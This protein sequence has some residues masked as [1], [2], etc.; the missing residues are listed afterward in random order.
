MEVTPDLS[1]CAAV[2]KGE[3]KEMLSVREEGGKLTVRINNSSLDILLNCWRKAD[4]VLNRQLQSG[5]QSPA[6]T[7]GLAIHKALEIFY[8][9]KREERTHLKNFKQRIELLQ[10]VDQEEEDHV[11]IKAARGFM[12]VAEPL[13]SLPESDKRS[14]QTGLWTLA[15]YFECYIDD[16][17]IALADESGPLVE[18]RVEFDLLETPEYRIKV[19]GTIDVI[20]KNEQSGAILVCDHKTSSVV[21]GEFYNRLKPNHQYTG[22][23]LG[24]KK[25]LGLETNNFMV[26][27]IQVKPKPKTS[28][29]TPP[30][31]PRQVTT[32]SEGDFTEFSDVVRVAV[33]GYLR[34]REEGIWP[35]GHVNCCAAYGGCQ[36][37]EICA[38]PESL[39]ENIIKAKYEEN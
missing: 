5:R 19:F 22:Y 28:R 32:R 39:R 16:P 24:A 31:F 27:C 35:L 33:E 12:K 34:R 2:V 14:I 23:V 9:S 38:A 25:C 8:S 1:G 4:Y 20:L 11:L 17:F 3:P 15:H 13:L 10:G 26:N 21:G 36:F 29:G 30:H 18:R 6:L 7:Y 37:L